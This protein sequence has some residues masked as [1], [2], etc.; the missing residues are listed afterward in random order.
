MYF[1]YLLETKNIG[2]TDINCLES[3]K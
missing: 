3:K 1:E 2:K